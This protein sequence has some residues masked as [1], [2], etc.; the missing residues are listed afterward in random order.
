MGCYIDGGR[1]VFEEAALVRNIWQQGFECCQRGPP[2]PG[3][4][5]SG[6][7]LRGN[8]I[9]PGLQIINNEF[10]GG[11]IFHQP[12]PPDAESGENV[13]VLGGPW[14]PKW[15]QNESKI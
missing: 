2:A 3:T 9:G 4:N 10:G 14:G 11:S 13:E 7:Y 1:A 12:T 5:G 8:K 15:N 6:I